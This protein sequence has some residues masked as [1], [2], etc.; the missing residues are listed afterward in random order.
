MAFILATSVQTHCVGILLIQ[1]LFLEW[2]T[3]APH[4]H[5][6]LHRIGL[7]VDRLYTRAYVPIAE[8]FQAIEST[9]KITRYDCTNERL[10]TRDLTRSVVQSQ[11]DLRNMPATSRGSVSVSE[12][13]NG[14]QFNRSYASNSSIL[15]IHQL[16]FKY[17]GRK[18][19]RLCINPRY[20]IWKHSAKAPRAHGSI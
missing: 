8:S 16:H 19:T 13:Q 17:S 1:F 10:S 6:Q 20:G 11:F 12:I 3:E 15:H 5:N 18:R 14:L 2:A 4:D 7:P 9:I